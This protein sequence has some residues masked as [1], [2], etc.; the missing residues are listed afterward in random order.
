MSDCIEGFDPPSTATKLTPVGVTVSAGAALAKGAAAQSS[1]VTARQ[2]ATPR[3]SNRLVLIINSS[4]CRIEAPVLTTSLYLKA[5]GRSSDFPF[6]HVEAN[7]REP[8][9]FEKV[10]SRNRTGQGTR[11]VRQGSPQVEGGWERID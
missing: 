8:R 6:G 11:A 9:E 10:G 7:C 3:G 2:R 4:R 1:I 5:P